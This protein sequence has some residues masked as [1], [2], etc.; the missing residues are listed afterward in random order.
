MKKKGMSAEEKLSFS[1]INYYMLAIGVFLLILGMYFLSLSVDG[2]ISMVI[3]PIILTFDFIVVF[4]FAI[5]YKPKK[6]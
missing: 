1:R 2:T 3:A 6:D 5:F 4:P